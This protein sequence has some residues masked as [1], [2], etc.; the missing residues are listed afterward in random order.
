MSANFEDLAARYIAVWNTTD[1]AS[2]RRAVDDLWVADGRYVDPLVD[3]HGR[4]AIDAT[5]GAVQSQFPG[6]V[7]RLTGRVDGHH[8]QVR[9]AW[10]L[11]PTDGEAP[12]AGFDVAIVD[13]DGRLS[14]VRGFLDRVPTP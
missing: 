8:D 13:A 7:F 11:G 2:R 9:F 1:P 3:A 12:V 5:I 4:D 6:L 10:E 14:E